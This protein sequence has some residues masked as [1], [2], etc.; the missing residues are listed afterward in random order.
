MHFRPFRS[1]YATAPRCNV[2]VLKSYSTHVRLIHSVFDPSRRSAA[3]SSSINTKTFLIILTLLNKRT[4]DKTKIYATRSCR[5]QNKNIPKLRET[6]SSYFPNNS[7]RLS[8]LL[9][10][11]VQTH[12]IV[13]FVQYLIFFSLPPYRVFAES[14]CFSPKNQPLKTNNNNDNRKTFVG[15][16]RYVLY[17][18]SGVLHKYPE[19]TVKIDDFFFS[20]KVFPVIV[21][22]SYK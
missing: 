14:V 15:R 9:Y 19:A 10:T 22:S 13:S 12:I 2:R 16:R 8:D 17:G 7:K 21:I 4:A 6:F 18:L 3:P 11:N 1:S 20:F 5:E